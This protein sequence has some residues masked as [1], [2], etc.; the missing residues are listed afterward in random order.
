MRFL[1]RFWAEFRAI[2][3][4]DYWEVDLDRLRQIDAIVEGMFLELH[5][6]RAVGSGM[7]RK[8]AAYRLRYQAQRSVLIRGERR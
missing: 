1:R 3:D 6:S 2:F 8:I 5:S 7:K 4:G